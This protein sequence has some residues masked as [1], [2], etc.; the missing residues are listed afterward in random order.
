M[1]GY[2]FTSDVHSAAGALAGARRILGEELP[3][4]LLD[5]GSGLGTWLRAAKAL[6]IADVVGIDAQALP[7]YDDL[8]CEVI[9]QDLSRPFDLGRRFDVILCLEVAEHLD[10]AS[11]ENL[12]ATLCRHGDRILFSAA[13]PGQ[14]GQNHIN[15]QW[16]AYWQACFNTAGYACSDAIRWQIWDDPEIEPWYRQNLFVAEKSPTKAGNEPR[17]RAAIHPDMLPFLSLLDRGIA[18]GGQLSMNWYVGNLS[19]A[20]KLRASRLIARRSTAGR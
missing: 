16:P 17:L 1:T 18:E 3:R 13:C 10:E 5:V 7:E 12:V 11:A 14:W 19:T 6:G 20:I 2:V 8:G 4:S 9:V 15:C